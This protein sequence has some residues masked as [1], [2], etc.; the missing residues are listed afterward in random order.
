MPPSTSVLLLLSLSLLPRGGAADCGENFRTGREDFVVD[1]KDSV[2]DGAALLGTVYVDSSAE[3]KNVCCSE[4]RCNMAL[5]QIGAAEAENRTCVLFNCVY[6]NRFVCRFANRAG[7]LSYVTKPVFQKY[8]RDPQRKGK[9]H[10]PIANAG[11]DI[12]VQPGE[13]VLLNGI[14][15]EA[16]GGAK[17]VDYSWSL[18]SG[19]E[20]VVMEKTDLPDQMNVTNLLPGLYVFKLTVTDSNGQ[21]DGDQVEVRVLDLQQSSLYCLTPMKPGPCRAAFPRWFYSAANGSCQ[22]FTF[23]GCKPN[24]NNYLS[25]E[26]CTA[27]C[28]GVTASFERSIMLPSSVCDSTC[29]PDQLKCDGHCCLD[30]SL[31]CDGVKH[32]ID[33]TDETYCSKLNHTFSRLMSINIDPREAQC[34]QSPHTGPCRASH[35]RWYY[36][37]VQRK[38]FQFT[39]GGCDANNNNF[40]RKEKCSSA[41]DGVTESSVFSRGMFERYEADDDDDDHEEGSGH[42]ALAVILT[43]SILALL[44]IG[45]YCVLRARKARSHEPV[46]TSPAATSSEQNTLVYNST[47]KPV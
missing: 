1:A 2:R 22:P 46:A 17:I 15:S 35:T 34:T 12:V 38:C 8:L 28:R 41:C 9:L 26:D 6:R 25:P 21:A 20:D 19:D 36:D 7:Y 27:A 37:P 14:E 3:C 44:A 16:L 32:C 43:V 13:A 47:T 23:G 31:E 24:Q 33:G 40:E 29:H 42:V 45:V 10:L 30:R 39:Y 5:F 4:P 18:E 11:R